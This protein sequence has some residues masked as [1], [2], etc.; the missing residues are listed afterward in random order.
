[1]SGRSLERQLEFWSSL[2]HLHLFDFLTVLQ[3]QKLSQSIGT[4]DPRVL[5]AAD[6]IS[7]KF[8]RLPLTEPYMGEG[9]A[10]GRQ[11]QGRPGLCSKRARGL[12][13]DEHALINTTSQ[14]TWFIAF[15]LATWEEMYTR[16]LAL[17]V[18]FTTTPWG[19]LRPW[20][21]RCHPSGPMVLHSPR[22]AR[23]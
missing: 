10:V 5:K 9:H 1:M 22:P 21:V 15:Q 23:A 6:F 19:P 4:A 2:W 3:G 20:I 13:E 18:G 14:N 12:F 17:S 8:I 16:G 7:S 11:R